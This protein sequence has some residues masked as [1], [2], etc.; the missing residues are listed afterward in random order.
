MRIKFSD[1]PELLK[2]LIDTKDL[3]L[4]EA[5][6]DLFYGVG[7]SITNGDILDPTMWKGQNQLGQILCGIRA[8]LKTNSNLSYYDIHYSNYTYHTMYGTILK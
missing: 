1:N 7:L 4:V 3:I 5:G 2:E 8:A 6:I